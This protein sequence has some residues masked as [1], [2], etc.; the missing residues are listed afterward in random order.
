LARRPKAKQAR[1]LAMTT[2]SFA[3]FTFIPLISNSSTKRNRTLKKSIH[4][5]GLVLIDPI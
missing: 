2:F 1:R 3:P 4:G 5:L